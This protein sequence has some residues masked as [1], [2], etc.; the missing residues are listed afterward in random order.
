MRGFHM[1]ERK[2][3]HKFLVNNIHTIDEFQMYIQIKP[4]PV[5]H[6]TLNKFNR[7]KR[8]YQLLEVKPLS[9]FHY[10]GLLPNWITDNVSAKIYLYLDYEVADKRWKEN[11]VV[12]NISKAPYLRIFS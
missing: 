1:S 4:L 2:L 10:Y 5:F 3:F 12:F 8:I 9:F 11:E 6:C 7:Y